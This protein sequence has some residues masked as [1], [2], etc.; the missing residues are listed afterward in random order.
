MSKM[1]TETARKRR[2]IDELTSNSRQLE[3]MSAHDL[4][5]FLCWLALF[6]TEPHERQSLIADVLAELA[7]D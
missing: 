4:R 6:Y 1:L 2:M 7:D 5:R 3:T